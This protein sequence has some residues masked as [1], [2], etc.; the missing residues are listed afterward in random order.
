MAF[1]HI[2]PFLKL[3]NHRERNRSHARK[4]RQRKRSLTETL[5]HSATQ[6]REENL[7]LRESIYEIIG[8]KK[9]LKILEARKQRARDQFLAGLM[10]P[11]N[12]IIKTA[13]KPFFKRLRKGIPKLDE[14]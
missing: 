11:E 3:I 10:V 8:Q 7:K 14:E 2:R 13:D 9:T 1:S 12:R 6:L 4:S 5:Q